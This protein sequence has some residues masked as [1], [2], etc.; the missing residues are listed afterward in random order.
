[1]FISYLK[2]KEINAHFIAQAYLR[3]YKPG[4]NRKQ[5]KLSCWWW[6]QDQDSM[7]CLLQCLLSCPHWLWALWSRQ[8]NA[9]PK[10]ICGSSS[11][12]IITKF[13]NLS[14]KFV[15]WDQDKGLNEAFKVYAIDLLFIWFSVAKPPHDK[16]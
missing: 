3:K 15:C 10:S 13:C 16:H 9:W 4:L 14:P 6:S 11:D 12:D 8:L 1:M 2:N 5:V 7:C